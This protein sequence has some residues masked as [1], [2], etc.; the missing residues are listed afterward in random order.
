MNIDL[1]DALKKIFGFIDKG[2]KVR[3]EFIQA[4]NDLSSAILMASVYTSSRFNNA[5][6]TEDR[7][8][9]IQ[10]LFST[11]KDKIEAHAR[12]NVF[13]APITQASNEILHF[14]TELNRIRK[15]YKDTHRKY[16]QMS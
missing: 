2:Q 4:V 13:C 1:L 5:I 8:S 11:D 3:N 7:T 10:I 15:N 6:S 14:F 16:G 12:M 9:K